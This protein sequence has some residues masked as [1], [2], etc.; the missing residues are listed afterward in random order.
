[1]TEAHPTKYLLA[2]YFFLFL[3][4]LQWIA[5]GMI[6][7]TFPNTLKN[8]YASLIFFTL[9]VIFLILFLFVIEKLKRVAIGKKNFMVLRGKGK[10]KFAKE[11]VKT[12]QLIPFVNLYR[13]KLK[14][15]KKAIYFFPPKNVNPLYGILSDYSPKKVKNF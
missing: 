9:G 10:Q 6:F 4:S 7:F 5:S 3:G 15:H 13:L 8:Q 1:M 14:G 2:R 11:N 12:L